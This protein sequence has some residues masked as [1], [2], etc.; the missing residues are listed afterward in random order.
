MTASDSQIGGVPD[1][2]EQSAASSRSTRRPCAICSANLGSCLR[3][4]SA[5]TCSI[6]A[7]EGALRSTELIYCWDPDDPPTR[8]DSHARTIATTST[9]RSYRL[10]PPHRRKRTAL[11]TATPA[12]VVLLDGA[13]GRT[14]ACGPPRSALRTGCGRC[15]SSPTRAVGSA[16]GVTAASPGKATSH[17]P[18]SRASGVRPARSRVRQQRRATPRR[19]PRRSGGVGAGWRRVLREGRGSRPP[20]G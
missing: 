12:L 8:A 17:A 7:A 1:V 3:R 5:R 18:L 9:R 14:A 11:N 15:P 2:D 6:G 20:S 10:A 13:R 19:D 4:C 16:G